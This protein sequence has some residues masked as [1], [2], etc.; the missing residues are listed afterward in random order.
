[1]RSSFQKC[2]ARFAISFLLFIRVRGVQESQSHAHGPGRTA[3]WMHRVAEELHIPIDGLIPK[4]LH[5]SKTPTEGYGPDVAARGIPV[6]GNDRRC[7]DIPSLFQVAGNE[8]LVQHLVRSEEHT[9]E[10][11]SHLNL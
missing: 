10:L 5:S 6:G 2:F 8:V 9:S 11:Q 7:G 4:F 3:F 1:M